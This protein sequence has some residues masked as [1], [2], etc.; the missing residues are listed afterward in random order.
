MELW[1]LYSADRTKLDRTHVRGARL[2]DDG[3]HL[4]VHVW[5]TRPDGRILLSRRA[6]SRPTFPL[7]WECV[8]GSV[9]AG[10]DSL[11]GACRE[12]YEEVGIRLSPANG[13]LLFTKTR[14][15]SDGKRYHDILDVWHFVTD[16]MPDLAAATTDEVCETREVTPDTLRALDAEGLLVPNLR[17]ATTADFWKNL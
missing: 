11:A 15:D 3:Y 12:A 9:L 7:L 10:E 6:A 13:K 1:D 14:H 4:V 8:G 2:P 17:Y 16:A 5:I